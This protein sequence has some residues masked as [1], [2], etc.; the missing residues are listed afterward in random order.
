[1]ENKRSLISP[2]HLDQR[3]AMGR[4]ATSLLLKYYILSKYLR[5]GKGGETGRSDTGKKKG[6]CDLL[7]ITNYIKTPLW[8]V[9][10]L[11]EGVHNCAA[12]VTRLDCSL[13]CSSSPTKCTKQYQYLQVAE[14]NRL[15]ALIRYN[16]RNERS[17]GDKCGA[18]RSRL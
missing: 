17:S 10:C 3:N 1:M 7:L 8:L 9:V 16:D 5:R 18:S 6:H 14:R 15:S 2:H 12:L 11:W 4:N 13:H